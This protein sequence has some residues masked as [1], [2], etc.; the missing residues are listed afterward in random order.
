[1]VKNHCFLSGVIFLIIS[2]YAQSFA[3]EKSTIRQEIDSL[4]IEVKEL[5]EEVDQLKSTQQ[6]AI[7]ETKTNPAYGKTLCPQCRGT[8]KRFV[9]C[10]VCNGSGKETYSCSFCNGRGKNGNNICNACK[11][12]GTMQ[13]TCMSCSALYSGL[14]TRGQSRRGNFE[15]CGFCGGSGKK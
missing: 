3:D 13:R 2:I 10:A 1:M 4:K 15:V 7:A 11:G 9:I 5:R 12:K 14:E 6:K 8:G